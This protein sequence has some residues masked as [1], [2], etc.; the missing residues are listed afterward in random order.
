MIERLKI[1]WYALTKRHYAFY[2]YNKDSENKSGAIC[3]IEDNCSTLF[4]DTIIEFTGDV[5]ND[6]IEKRL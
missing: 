5:K 4:L 2:A 6:T 1:C 3:I